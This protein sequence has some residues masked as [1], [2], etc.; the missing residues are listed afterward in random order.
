MNKPIASIHY[1]AVGKT[2]IE[3]A[4]ATEIETSVQSIF[5]ASLLCGW[6]R[7]SFF[8]YYFYLVQM[9]PVQINL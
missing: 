4:T 5:E 8:S 3:P 1:V 6:T 2:A 9:P 7:V